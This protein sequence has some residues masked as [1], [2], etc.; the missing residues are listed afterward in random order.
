M[1]QEVKTFV[2]ILSAL[3]KQLS[4]QSSAMDTNSKG[5]FLNSNE[6]L[7]W[8]RGSMEKH[9]FERQ[10]FEQRM[11]KQDERWGLKLDAPQHHYLT[12]SSTKIKKQNIV[13]FTFGRRTSSYFYHGHLHPL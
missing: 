3:E 8:S 9:A 12:N 4:R 7:T 5:D 2:N 1:R 10:L 6:K 11:R 13:P